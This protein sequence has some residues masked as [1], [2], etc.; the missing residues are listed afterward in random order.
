MAILYVLTINDPTGVGPFPPEILNS[1]WY[2]NFTNA[3]SF[4]GLSATGYVY[5][6]LFDSQDEL[7][8]WVATNTPTDPDVLENLAR[9]KTFSVTYENKFYTLPATTGTGIIN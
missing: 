5:S 2:V 8:A 3:Y 4:Q 7:N 9:W 6:W 1:D